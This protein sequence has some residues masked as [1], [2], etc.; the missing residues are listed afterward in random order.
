MRE[1]EEGFTYPHVDYARCK[2]CELCARTCPALRPHEHTTLPI[3]FLGCRHLDASTRMGSSSGGLFPALARAMIAQGGVVYGAALKPAGLGLVVQHR[4]ITHAGQL[5]ALQGSKYV[6]SAMG[7]VWQA[8]RAHL[9]QGPVLFSGTPCQVAAARALAGQYHD[10]LLTMDLICDGVASPKLFARYLAALGSVTGFCFRDKAGHQNSRVISWEQNNKKYF[11]PY[12]I[13]SFMHFYCTKLCM[14]PACHSCPYASLQRAGHISAG[15]FHGVEL[16]GGEL[17][18]GMGVSLALLNTAEG[19]A[20][21]QA[22]DHLFHNVEVTQAQAMQPR[23]QQPPQASS[24]RASFMTHLATMSY[25]QLEQHYPIHKNRQQTMLHNIKALHS[26]RARQGA[27][28]PPEISVLIVC[29]NYAHFLMQC[30]TSVG[31]QTFTSYEIILVDD[32]STDNTAQIAKAYPRVRYIRQEHQ[33]VAAARNTAVRA[34][35]GQYLAFLDADDYWPVQRLATLLNH[36][37]ACAPKLVFGAMR[38]FYHS[39]QVEDIP[40][41]RIMARRSQAVLPSLTLLPRTFFDLYG[42]FDESKL[43]GEDSDYMERLVAARLEFAHIKAPVLYRRLH[44]DN[45]SLTLRKESFHQDRLRRL[46]A[47]IRKHR[48]A[49][50]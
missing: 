24:Q 29:Y 15:D 48:K 41:A 31:A 28:N 9:A 2:Q 50:A 32:G 18:D 39:P 1:D 16:V 37:K 8:L 12:I 30:L 22:V 42:W 25:P 36:A 44:G 20:A 3:K 34:A 33:G 21:W 35:R 26:L 23:L 6:Q 17:D 45:I 43:F 47:D 5:G 14:R 7:G 38:N 27:Q 13:N 46:A 10:R 40:L 4:P 11:S 49:M 19:M